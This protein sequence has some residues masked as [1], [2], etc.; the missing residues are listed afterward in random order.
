MEQ[1][2]LM[3]VDY[4]RLVCGV[5]QR[6]VYREMIFL[7]FHLFKS[8]EETSKTMVANFLKD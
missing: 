6:F 7:K 8:K 4:P 1:E 5:I 2:D 3:E